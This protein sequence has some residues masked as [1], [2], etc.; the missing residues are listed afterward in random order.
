MTLAVSHVFKHPDYYYRREMDN[1]IALLRLETPA[2][3][4]TYILPACLPPS[5]MAER[6]L[7]LN[8]TGTVV[9][10][11]GRDAPDTGHFSS[12]L[13]V[14]K[15]PLVGAPRVPAAHG[16]QRVGEH[17]LR[18]RA[19]HRHGRVRGGQRRAHGHAVPGHLV[20]TGPGVLGSGLRATQQAGRLHQGVQLRG[21]DRK[22][23]ARTGTGRT[24]RNRSLV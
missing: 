20:P 15:V 7:H 17:A 6:V 5:A 3:L 8:G 18:R 16:H 19:G 11:W 22:V 2:P 12:A 21:L 23:C 24:G 13:N 9:T 10:G 14:I 4:S 1:D